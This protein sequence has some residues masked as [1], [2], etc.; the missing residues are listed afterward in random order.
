VKEG[1]GA[2]EAAV[3]GLLGL[4][5]AFTFSGAADRFNV[6][7]QRIVEEANSIGTAYLRLDLLPA[8]EQPPLRDLFRRY[9]DERLE[10]YRKLPDIKAAERELAHSIQLQKEI[11]AGAMAASGE[12]SAPPV[13]MLLLPALNEMFDITTTRT[14]AMRMHPPVVIYAMLVALSLAGSLLAGY[15]MARAK[16]R[17]WFHIFGYAIIMTAAVYV[18]LDLEFP[19]AGFIRVDAFDQVL[20]ETRKSMD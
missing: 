13:R 4:L 17:G 3:F 11:W 18:I 19:R 10:V 12:Q 14:A 15:G 1:A 9:L 16:M 20:V 8:E 2:V 6:R 5:L 7:R